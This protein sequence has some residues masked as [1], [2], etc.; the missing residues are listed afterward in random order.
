MISLLSCAIGRAGD[1]TVCN[2]PGS[3]HKRHHQDG[4]PELEGRLQQVNDNAAVAAARPFDLTNAALAQ[5]AGAAPSVS[6]PHRDRHPDHQQVTAYAA[7][8]LLPR[9]DRAVRPRTQDRRRIGWELE[10]ARGFQHLGNWFPAVAKLT[11]FNGAVSC[12]DGAIG[13]GT[14]CA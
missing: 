11:P 5:G 2:L 10:L 6:G 14:L 9:P 3:K 12:D 7:H 13:V 4:S 1:S 8:Q